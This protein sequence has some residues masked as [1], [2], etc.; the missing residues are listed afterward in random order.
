MMGPARE[1]AAQKAVLGVRR[2]QFGM[3]LGLAPELAAQKAVLGAHRCQFDLLA[4]E[5]P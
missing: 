3:E 2:C 1:L 4:E 5:G